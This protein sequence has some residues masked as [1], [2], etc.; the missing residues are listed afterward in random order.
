MRVVLVI[1]EEMYDPRDPD[2][3]KHKPEKYVDAEFHVSRALRAMGHDVIA[4]PATNDLAKMIAAVQ[5]ARPGVAFNLVEHVGGRRSNDSV[6]AALLEAVGIPYTG[7]P[8]EALM[9]YRNKHLS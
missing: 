8:P 1:D 5:R 9:N 4:V 2:L 3:S 7:A 6:V